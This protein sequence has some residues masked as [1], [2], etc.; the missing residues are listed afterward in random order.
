MDFEFE[1]MSGDL[2][3]AI[4]STVNDELRAARDVRVNVLPRDEAFAIP[5]SSGRRSTCSPRASRRSA[6]SRSSA[7][8]SRPTAARTSPTPARSA[9]IR[10]TGYESKGRSTSGSGSS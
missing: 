10:V 3:E 7:S 8:T 5:T 1:R 9:G 2:V 4:E 6:R